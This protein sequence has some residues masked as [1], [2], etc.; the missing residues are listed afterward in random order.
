MAATIRK[1]EPTDRAS[2]IEIFNSNCPQ[3]FDP[4]EI[5]GLE[6]W[7][8]G[9]DS[10]IITYNT[11]AADSF[12]VLELDSRVIGCGGYYIV[13]G[14]ECANLV[15]GMVHHD[16]HGQGMGK[17]LLLYRLDEIRQLYPQYPVQMDTT[18]HTFLFFEKLG[19]VVTSITKDAYGPSLDRYDMKRG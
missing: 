12:S 7:L 6:T 18:Q 19:F 9:Q 11:S 14:E 8:N 17:E 10:G 15:W 13:K 5:G 1:Y 3:Y 2:C 16:F 4:T